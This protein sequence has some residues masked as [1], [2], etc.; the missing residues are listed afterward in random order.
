MLSIDSLTKSTMETLEQL[1]M[2]M[3]FR[4]TASLSICQCADLPDTSILCSQRA[5]NS[6]FESEMDKVFE[7]EN[8]AEDE[9]CHKTK[10]QKVE[11]N[12]PA[13]M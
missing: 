3:A 6:F 12:P 7:V 9:A 10:R 8:S 5:L 11:E 1:G 13:A 2:C 4:Y